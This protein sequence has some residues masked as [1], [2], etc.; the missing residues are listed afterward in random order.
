V[1]LSQ[2]TK[3]VVAEVVANVISP[4][5]TAT[6]FFAV[7]FALR[8]YN[9]GILKGSPRC[10]IYERNGRSGRCLFV[11]GSRAPASRSLSAK[12][13]RLPPTTRILSTRLIR[14]TL[15]FHS[16]GGL[17][18]GMPPANSF[19]L[20]LSWQWHVIWSAAAQ[21]FLAKARY[22]FVHG[23]KGSRLRVGLT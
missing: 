10:C 12:S 23:R 18:Q 3:S 21:G 1:L 14:F 5:A 2:P 7:V 9:R 15:S 11:W 8:E 19:P 17:T 22:R 4:V 20:T 16:S 13:A 6:T